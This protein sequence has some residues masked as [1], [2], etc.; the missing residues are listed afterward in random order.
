[1]LIIVLIKRK[2]ER[3]SYD[4]KFGHS[5]PSE[6]MTHPY[7][8]TWGVYHPISLKEHDVFANQ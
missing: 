4:K 5:P 7:T 2:L 1:M 3:A 8:P 6:K